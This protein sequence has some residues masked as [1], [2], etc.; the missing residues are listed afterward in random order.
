MPESIEDGSWSF[1][2]PTLEVGRPQSYYVGDTG[3]DLYSSE[4]VCRGMDISRRNR[5]KEARM[6]RRLQRS[7]SCNS[8]SPDKKLTVISLGQESAFNDLDV[9]NVF[10][11]A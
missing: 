5:F 10:R 9:G 11:P 1:N 6:R 7:A 8:R 3:L 2:N 4:N